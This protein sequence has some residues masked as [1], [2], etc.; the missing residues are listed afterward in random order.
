MSIEKKFVPPEYHLFSVEEANS[1]IPELELSFVKL[2]K[3]NSE[4]AMI[5]EEKKKLSKGNGKIHLNNDKVPVDLEI[6]T[7]NLE[8]ISNMVGE[9]QDSGVIIKDIETGLVD[10]PHRRGDRIVYLCWQSGENKI[11]FWHEIEA[12]KAGRQPL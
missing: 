7:K 4:V 2:R 8:I 1:L 3:L 11:D 12:G 9:I 10:F 6:L 5:V